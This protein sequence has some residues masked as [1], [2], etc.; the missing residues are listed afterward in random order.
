MTHEEYKELLLDI[1]GQNCSDEE[2]TKQLNHIYQIKPVGQLWNVVKAESLLKSGR[3]LAEVYGLLRNFVNTDCPT[4]GDIEENR[5]LQKLDTIAG[6]IPISKYREFEIAQCKNDLSYL[7]RRLNDEKKEE[8]IFLENENAERLRDEYLADCKIVSNYILER[9]LNFLKK[10][11]RLP[12]PWIEGIPNFGFLKEAIDKMKEF[13]L[14]VSRECEQTEIYILG[15]VLARMGCKVSVIT[16]PSRIDI[17]EP[18]KMQE[19]VAVSMDNI[20]TENGMQFIP[21]VELIC[22]GRSLGN[23]VAEIINSLTGGM[24]RNKLFVLL[25]SSCYMEK[26]AAMDI[27]RKSLQNLYIQTSGWKKNNITFGW[28]GS[29]LT[30][31]SEIYHMDAEAAIHKTPQCRFSVVIPARNSSTTLRHTLKT[32]LNQRYR[33]SYEII[34]SDNSSDG[35]VEVYNMVQEINDA[36]IK[37]FR[38]PRELH[39]PKSFEY[40]FLQASGEYIFSIGSD[41][42]LLPWTLEVL[43]EVTGRYPDE[44]VIYWER[45]FYAWPGFNG[46]QENQFV[47]PGRYQKGQYNEGYVNAASF[48]TTAL[49]NLS[50]MYTMPLLY[51][52]SVFKR[53]YFDTLLSHT[54]R[55]WDGVCQ[56]LY[57]GV[58]TSLIV[59]RILCL[60]Y[61][62]SIAGMSPRSVGATSNTAITKLSEGVKFYRDA[63]ITSNIGGFAMS[64]TEMLFPEIT[65]D[66]SSFY[67]CVLRA[68]ARGLLPER[69]LW[70]KDGIDWKTW[71]LNCYRTLNKGDVYFMLKIQRFRFAAMKHGREFLKWFDE[72]IYEEALK[73]EILPERDK[74]IKTYR[75]YNDERG[76]T[77]DASKYGVYNSYE[78]SL[79]FEKMTGL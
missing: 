12:R 71:F 23:N 57:M 31:I 27:L 64:G 1:R 66:V 15:L 78:A 20:T 37:Y 19:T 29:Y 38:T 52:N 44:E 56:D 14:C 59:P 75:E 4:E 11:K 28:V 35:K 6:D 10:D 5:I 30:Y 18:I 54:G 73:P 3:G 41:D 62:L 55:L 40:A 26:L 79:L 34:I 13:I 65:T 51:I 36:R 7:E 25:A 72:T 53:S 22:D 16:L 67:N 58:V 61:P 43:D 2:K 47:I 45:G 42:A 24:Q 76:M 17:E 21:A 60:Q 49:E 69:I 50:Y 63:C 9:Y 68:V 8:Q 74:T 48:L 33:G 32:C 39:L 77:L 46:G 70:D